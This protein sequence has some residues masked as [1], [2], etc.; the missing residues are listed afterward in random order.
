MV[1]VR[2]REKEVREIGEINPEGPEVMVEYEPICS[3]VEEDFSLAKGNER[4]ETPSLAEG[5]LSHV[6]VK[7]QE[8]HGLRDS[9][10]GASGNAGPAAPAEGGIHHSLS[11]LDRDGPKG[12]SFGTVAA[13]YAFVDVHRGNS[14]SSAGKPRSPTHELP[15]PHSSAPAHAA[16]APLTSSLAPPGASPI[17]PRHRFPPFALQGSSAFI[18]PGSVHG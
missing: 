7:D 11:V 15:S 2:V 14:R 4:R 16:A 13:A 3:G 10:F 6:V 8:A 18:V 9:A 12:A 1:T 17:V 5:W